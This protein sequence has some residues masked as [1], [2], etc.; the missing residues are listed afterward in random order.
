[1]LDRRDLLKLFSALG[2]APLLGHDVE[3]RP[4]DDYECD[5]EDPETISRMLVPP[6]LP[7]CIIY[8]SYAR[9]VLDDPRMFRGPFYVQLVGAGYEYDKAHT[10]TLDIRDRILG[11]QLLRVRWESPMMHAE[12]DVEFHFHP[13]DEVR[14]TGAVLSLEDGRLFMWIRAEARIFKAAWERGNRLTISFA[15]PLLQVHA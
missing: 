8:P 2:I 10:T 12:H 5:D 3:A 11:P 4:P 1:M 14:T 7:G 9:A 15:K 13:R 6:A